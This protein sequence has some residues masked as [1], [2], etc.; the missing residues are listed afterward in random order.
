MDNKG[1]K[2]GRLDKLLEAASNVLNTLVYNRNS[3]YASINNQLKTLQANYNSLLSKYNAL[4]DRLV[5]YRQNGTGT[6]TTPSGMYA[7]SYGS[8][9]LDPSNPSVSNFQRGINAE[10]SAQGIGS[11]YKGEYEGKLLELSEEGEAVLVGKEATLD[12]KQKLVIMQ[13]QALFPPV[14]LG[15]KKTT[16]KPIENENA[17]PLLYN[18]II[19]IGKNNKVDMYMGH[20]EFGYRGREYFLR[21]WGAGF[22]RNILINQIMEKARNLRFPYSVNFKRGFFNPRIEG[23]EFSIKTYGP[24]LTG[25]RGYRAVLTLNEPLTADKYAKILSTLEPE[26]GTARFREEENA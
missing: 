11:L 3:N 4:I 6:Q 26:S 18:D 2:R 25:L 7:P 8:G 10:G 12:T 16:Y 20:T 5:S 19:K 24:L 15:K 9:G 23:K 1:K 22:N 17:L 13:Q 14:S 21:G